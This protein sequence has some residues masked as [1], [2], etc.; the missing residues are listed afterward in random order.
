MI[1][2]NKTI[3]FLLLWGAIVGV[4]AGQKQPNVI[5]FSYDDLRPE[6]GAY[7][8]DEVITPALD[9]LAGDGVRFNNAVVSYPLCLPSRSSMLTGIRFDNKN[10]VRNEPVPEGMRKKDFLYLSM[11]GMQ[12][13]WPQ[14]LREA[15]YWTATRGKL[16]HGNVP[17]G[18]KKYWD[19]PGST[20]SDPGPYRVSSELL[21]KVVD[22]GGV[23]K[24]VDKMMSGGSG[25]GAL[26]Y[27][28]IDCDDNEL[29]EG[30][31]ADDV[32]DYLLNKRDKS[33]P[34][35]ICA[36]FSRPHL[37]WVAP[38][39]Y[40]DMYPEDAGK[41][42]PVP[43]GVKKVILKKDYRP[44]SSNLWNEGLSDSEAKKLIRAYMATTTYADTQMGRIIDAL[45]ESG[46]YDNTII[47]MWGDHG[48]HLS[49]HGLWQKN[50]DY[51][52]SNR[53]PLII[54]A[55]GIK[56]GKQ[57]NRMVQN[58]D[59]YPTLMALTGVKK[60]EDVKFHGHDLTPLLKNPKAKWKYDANYTCWGHRGVV[61]EQYRFTDF[62]K[63]VYELYDLTI[64]PEEWNNLAN[65]PKYADLVKEF[66]YKSDQV[67]W[68]K[69]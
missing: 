66:K 43:E 36:G 48:Y 25:P 1:R 30:A 64:D 50:K 18:H 60:P 38:K 47:I 27:L 16:Y 17:K 42:A 63:G 65:Q 49:E 39:K 67:V 32:I 35:A 61:T 21:K 29:H 10:F 22:K 56:G 12:T 14:V 45:K 3:A 37:P 62:G 24:D 13:T 59:I 54:K 23:Q 31:V 33:K 19:I 26:A 28:S 68:N 51:L 6:I 58:I 69:K 9:A 20:Y 41:L 40:F 8:S 55:P 11:L 4:A 44:I 2:L 53:F 52:V 34:F 7:N 15:G 57:S 5:V 46:E